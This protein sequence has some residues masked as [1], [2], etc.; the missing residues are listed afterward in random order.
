MATQKNQK[1][2]VELEGAAVLAAYNAWLAAK[3]AAEA[4]EEAKKA[5]EA[6]LHGYLDTKGA[7]VATIGKVKVLNRVKF[8]RRT[9]SAE[10]LLK[11]APKAAQKASVYSPVVQLRKS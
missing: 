5:A 2:A 7:E 9:F 10:V 8:D 4:A 1:V 3:N 11:L 6:I